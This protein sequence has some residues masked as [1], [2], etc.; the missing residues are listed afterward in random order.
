[1]MRRQPVGRRAGCETLAIQ[2]PASR[3][4]ADRLPQVSNDF[5]IVLDIAITTRLVFAIETQPEPSEQ[6]DRRDRAF[7]FRRVGRRLC[8]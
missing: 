8:P 7:Q 3:G 2:E 4:Y 6:G 1:M 5:N